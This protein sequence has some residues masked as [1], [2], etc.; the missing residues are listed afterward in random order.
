MSE[1]HTAQQAGEQISRFYLS[2]AVSAERMLENMASA[3]A[4]GLPEATPCKPHD[5]LLSVAGGGP[6]LADTYQDLTGFTCAVNGSLSWL[7]D[8]G[9]KPYAC[10]IMDAGEHIA[11]AIVADPDVRYYVASICDPKVFDKLKDCDVRLWHV[12][13]NATEDPRGVEDVLNKAHPERWHSIGGGCTMGLRWINL[14]YFLGFRRFHLHGLDS[15]FRSGA[16]HA[17]PDR[18]DAKEHITFDGHDTKLSFLAQL[19]DFGDMLEWLWELDSN[20]QLEVFGEGLVQNEWKAFRQANP[21][22]FRAC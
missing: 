6:S 2:P 7:L 18:D 12:S 14:G 9:V 22:A 20:V 4:R 5:M 8:Q 15:S 11:D 10:G 19:H 17:Y 1:T 16:T 13:P 3:I 21:S